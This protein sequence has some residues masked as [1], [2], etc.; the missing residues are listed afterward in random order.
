MFIIYSITDY[1]N[2]EYAKILKTIQF[3]CPVQSLELMNVNQLIKITF[4]V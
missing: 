2:T 1:V 4:Q 3:L